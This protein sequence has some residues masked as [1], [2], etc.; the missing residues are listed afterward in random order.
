MRQIYEEQGRMLDLS[1][2]VFVDCIVVNGAGFMYTYYYYT[3][4]ENKLY[5]SHFAT[6]ESAKDAQQN[7]RAAWNTYKDDIALLRRRV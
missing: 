5:H 2:L 4:Y 3:G 7:L 6:E 1:R